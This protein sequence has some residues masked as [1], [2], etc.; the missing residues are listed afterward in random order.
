MLPFRVA[1]V[2]SPISTPARRGPRRSMQRPRNGAGKTPASVPIVY[3]VPIAARESRR[4]WATRSKK[5]ENPVLLAEAW[6]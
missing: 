5:W 4:S 1:T 2:A 3:A 6:S